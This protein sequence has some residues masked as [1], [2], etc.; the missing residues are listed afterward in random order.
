MVEDTST[1]M[2]KSGSLLHE[3]VEVCKAI[4]PE[5]ERGS[6]LVAAAYVEEKLQAL[7]SAHFVAESVG[8]KTAEDN[9]FEGTGPLATFSAKQKVAWACGCINKDEYDKLER[10]RKIRNEYA[11]AI[12]D[13]RPD[14]PKV[15]KHLNALTSAC[16]EFVR[17]QTSDARTIFVLSALWLGAGFAARSEQVSRY[18][19]PEIDDVVTSE[20]LAQLMREYEASHPGDDATIDTVFATLVKAVEKVSK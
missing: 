9:L 1:S 6:V 8:S 3:Y 7:L 4:V 12:F 20:M 18:T 19:E 10:I 2:S 11:H 16:P 17:V 14:G 13:A 15:E 5:S